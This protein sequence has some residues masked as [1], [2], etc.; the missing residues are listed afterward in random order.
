M[1]YNFHTHTSRCHHATGKAEEY[2]LSA[3]EGGIKYMG[4]SDHIPLMHDDGKQSWYRVPVEEGK[5]YC[6]EIKILAKKYESKIELHVGFEAEYFPQYFDKMINDAID[7]GAEYLILGQHF[8][9]PPNHD[10]KIVSCGT[11]SDKELKN[12]VNLVIAA[13]SEGVF[14]YVAHPDIFSFLGDENIYKKEMTRLCKAST[15]FSVPLEINFLGIRDN[16][17]YPNP[18]F[19]QIAGKCGSPVTF[20]LDAHSAD[21]AFDGQSHVYAMEMVEKYKLNYIGKPDLVP[22]KRM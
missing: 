1:D 12:Y 10:S 3:I 15:I 7:F 11:D 21:A 4:F 9:C 22:L 6:D 17:S 14:T 19:W 20:G 5:E 8:L 16:R 18:A 2:V 13:M